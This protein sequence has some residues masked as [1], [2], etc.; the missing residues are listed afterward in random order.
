[1]RIDVQAI[2]DFDADLGR[3]IIEKP[4]DYLPLVSPCL[5][6]SSAA[7]GNNAQSIS[8]P[9]RKN[10]NKA[11]R[12]LMHAARRRGNKDHTHQGS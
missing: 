6:V 7:F 1:M 3:N 9:K 10:L 4:T 11:K 12:C 8:P 5:D 2:Q